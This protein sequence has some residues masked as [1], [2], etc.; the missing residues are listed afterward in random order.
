M[1][2]ELISIGKF[3]VPDYRRH[4]SKI[5]INVKPIPVGYELRC[6]YGSDGYSYH[7]IL[8]QEKKA[9][10][11]KEPLG[12]QVFG[13][14]VKVIEQVSE[15]TRHEFF[16]DN[17]FT[18]YDLMLKLALQSMRLITRTLT[19]QFGATRMETYHC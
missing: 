5:F 6:L 12:I 10:R 11:S 18:N 3:R 13:K 8:Y 1:F 16:F 2:H 17:F 15:T 19:Q 9:M 14:I 4:S 7:F